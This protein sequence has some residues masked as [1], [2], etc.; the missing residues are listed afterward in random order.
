MSGLDPSLL[1]FFNSMAVSRQRFRVRPVG[2][3]TA[4]PSDII[5]VDLPNSL[6]DL[7]TAALGWK[8]TTAKGA[9]DCDVVRLSQDTSSLFD[10][11]QVESAGYLVDPGCRQSNRLAQIA[12]DW[13][14]APGK[15]RLKSVL[16]G[17]YLDNQTWATHTAEHM[18]LNDFSGFLGSCQPRK[19]DVSLM[20]LR[21]YF[22]VA[23]A[24][25]A[26]IG[27]TNGNVAKD[28]TTATI[29]LSN[30]HFY[31]DAIE[32][33]DGG[34]YSAAI[35][36]RLSS[37]PIEI[38]W[39]RHYLVQSGPVS[40]GYNSL[41]MNLSVQSLDYLIG[42]FL[43]GDKQPYEA[44]RYPSPYST[45]GGSNVL[46]VDGSTDIKS[47]YF[48]HSIGAGN[49][50]VDSQFSVNAVTYPSFT[51]DI[52]ESYDQTVQVLGKLKSPAYGGGKVWLDSLANYR[53]YAAMHAVSF[54][55]PN[56]NPESRLKSGLNTL[57]NMASLTWNTNTTLGV[58]AV[59]PS[60]LLFAGTT[61]ILR[62][63]QHKSVENV[64]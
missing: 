31:V 39:R 10:S 19:I 63:G 45:G 14:L 29:T 60:K 59:P 49:T 32:I 11:I 44:V 53:D 64:A 12:L 13:T 46:I 7:D 38:P 16:N 40:N 33:Q 27:M 61:S 4:G 18:R 52:A 50:W 24:N 37:G 55:F 8:L 58:G 17:Q 2:M 47:G 23:D 35:S 30:I 21:V 48:L 22:K 20:G 56:G 1:F 34:V 15:Q 51:A 57:G 54:E 36:R 28:P 62:V 26:F 9:S 43:S 3:D 5:V 25:K 42:V 6:L 41:L